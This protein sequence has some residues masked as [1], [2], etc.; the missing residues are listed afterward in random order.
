MG[1]LRR[2]LLSPGMLREVLQGALLPPEALLLV[3]SLRN[4]FGPRRLRG[5]APRKVGSLPRSGA[6][7]RSRRTRAPSRRQPTP[8][9]SRRGDAQIVNLVRDRPLEIR[10]LCG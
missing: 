1:R 5:A 10:V 4:V 9:T 6:T 3:D 7:C 2:L 8:A